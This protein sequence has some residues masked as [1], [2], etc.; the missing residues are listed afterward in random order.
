MPPP[1]LE[2]L[3][4]VRI[5]ER[6]FWMSQCTGIEPVTLC[7]TSPFLQP[8]RRCSELEPAVQPGREIERR[9]RLAPVADLSVKPHAHAIAIFHICCSTGADVPLRRSRHHQFLADA[10]HPAVSRLSPR[11]SR[12][13]FSWW[14]D[15]CTL[16]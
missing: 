16:E 6:G 7:F 9:R 12:F 13:P 4:D 14:L 11:A 10:C 3:R 8:T 15:C 5:V 1:G 2:A